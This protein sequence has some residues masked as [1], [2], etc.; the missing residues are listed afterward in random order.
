MKKQAFNPYLPSYEYVPDG[1]PHVFGDRLYVF[2]SH[3]RFG[4]KKFCMNDYVCWSAPV[5]DPADWRY[6]GV[7]YKKVQDPDNPDGTKVIYAPDVAQGPDGR[8]YLYYGLADDTKIGVAVCDTPA[9]EYSFLACVH[10]KAGKSWGRREGDFMPFDPGILADDDGRVHLYAGQGPMF[11]GKAAKEHARHFRDSAYYVELEP[12]MVTMKT[13]PKRLLP[14]LTDSA[15]TGFE[16]HEFHEANSIRK[17][18]GKYYFIYSSVQSHEL[19]WAVSDRPDG[20]FRYGGVLTSNGDIGPDGVPGGFSY[21]KPLGDL[22]KN[23]IGNNHGS[24]VK[25]GENY[26]LFGHRQTNRSMFSRQGY[27]EK[28]TFRNGAFSYAE[29][30]SCGLNGGPLR[31]VGTYEARIACHLRSA[32]GCVFSAH[33]MVQNWK[34]PAFTQDGEDREED[35]SQYIQNLRNGANALFRYFDFSEDRPESI[36]LS[37][38]GRCE[39]VMQVYDSEEK[40]ELLASI[41]VSLKD[42]KNW[43]TV[44]A[45][46]AAPSGVSSLYFVYSGKGSADFMSFTLEA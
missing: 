24:V 26:Y 11:A 10:D 21:S 34:H 38:R 46:F 42:K 2:G 18:D 15:G 25:L 27:A 5:G 36:R 40:K 7:I 33:P 8:F 12:D 6:E 31:G 23:Y 28:I 13:E 45:H 9:G 22:A 35:P 14:N 16:K 39:G 1:E 3:D 41:P 29:L 37:L 43:Q 17:F 44:S 4:G 32:K 19:C 20:G 30:T